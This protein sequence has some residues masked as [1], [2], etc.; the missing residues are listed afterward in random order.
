MMEKEMKL[1]EMTK[2]K[3]CWAC[4][5]NKMKLEFKS[6]TQN[7][8]KEMSG[9]KSNIV[10]VFDNELE[11]NRKDI[12]DK[13]VMLQEFDEWIRIV[14]KQ[15]PQDSFIRK[16]KDVTRFENVYIISWG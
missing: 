10:R 2:Q 6:N 8:Y 16:I 13:M 1:F 11:D 12:L 15:K 5:S 7:Y 3:K 4:G 9:R 14:H